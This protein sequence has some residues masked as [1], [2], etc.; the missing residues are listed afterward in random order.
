[1][2]PPPAGKLG[3]QR[4]RTVSKELRYSRKEVSGC[5]GPTSTTQPCPEAEVLCLL[6]VSSD[7]LCGKSTSPA[8]AS[9]TP[10]GGILTGQG[11]QCPILPRPA[12]TGQA[13]LL[14]QNWLQVTGSPE[15][16]TC[17]GRFLPLAFSGPPIPGYTLWLAVHT[18]DVAFSNSDPEAT[19][20]DRWVRTAQRREAAS[21]PL[22]LR[23]IVQTSDPRSTTHSGLVSGLATRPQGF[24]VCLGDSQ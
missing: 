14:D 2:Q 23:A 16:V 24:G 9:S 22:T 21:W 19:S 11:G 12:F 17:H 4:W 6:W 15:R 10:E 18:Q 20:M 1:M 13:D 7:G 3:T 5:L 8:F